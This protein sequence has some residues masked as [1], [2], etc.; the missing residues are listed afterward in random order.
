[1]VADEGDRGNGFQNGAFAEDTERHDT[2]NGDAPSVSFTLLN[3]LLF[4]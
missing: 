2:F 3:P 1:M 4:Q